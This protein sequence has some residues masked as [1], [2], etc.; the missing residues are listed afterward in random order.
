[1][2]YEYIQRFKELGFGMYVHFGLYS[3]VGRGEWHMYSH[4]VK[5]ETY[6]RLTKKFNIKKN[7]AK[8]LVAVAKSAGCKYITLTTR[9]HD[10]FSLYDTKG[11]N[12]YDAPHSKTGRDLVREFVDECNKEGILPC[13]YHTLLDWH[14]PDYKNNFPSYI[15]YLAKSIEIL[16][17]SYGKIGGFEFDGMWDRPDD[18]WQED[19]LYGIIRRY[20][21]EAMIINNTGLHELGKV[22]HPEIDSVTFERGDP[23]P[24]NQDGKPLA[25]EMA[26]ILNDHWG[27][28]KCDINYKSMGTILENLVDCRLCNCNFL[29]NIGPMGNGL[30]R[31]M[32]AAFLSEIGKFIKV[33]KGFIYST[34]RAEISADG[35][36]IL[37]D[38][39]YYYAIVKNVRMSSSPN[40]VMDGVDTKVTVLTNKKIKNARWLD[41]G[42][43]QSVKKNSFTARPYLYGE[44]YGIRVLRFELE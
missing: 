4:H 40:V 11:L 2:S 21:P 43:A 25:G 31:P 6:E 8:E 18:D 23:S 44:S 15:D 24:V 9:H 41:S 27:Y 3:T 36:G 22:G 17:T 29:L 37:T 12:D 19:R 32:D 1:M 5:T 16:C 34:Y 26:Q 20:Q 39:K 42:R 13:F 14:H 7:W 35:A 10:G 33:N 38:G 30:V 28:A